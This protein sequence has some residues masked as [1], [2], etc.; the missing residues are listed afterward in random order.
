MLAL[1]KKKK[2]GPIQLATNAYFLDPEAA[3][4]IL[5]IGI[6]F[7]SFSMDANHPDV[8]RKIRKNSDFK[9]VYSNALFFLEEKKRRGVKLPEVQISAVKT[10][11]N[12]RFMREFVD[13][14][15]GK[16]AG[17]AWAH[18]RRQGRGSQKALP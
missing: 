6:D 2:I 12:S 3:K 18:C 9:K 14:W 1:A 13:F 17:Q 16:A 15:R 10:D 5:D 7:I 11:K 4:G 8:Y